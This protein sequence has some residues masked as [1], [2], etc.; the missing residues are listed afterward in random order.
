MSIHNNSAE[1][2]VMS[3]DAWDHGKG[4]SGADL[5]ITT[6]F[7]EIFDNKPRE[8]KCLID[9]G[10]THSFISPLA[11]V[12]KD[13][14]RIKA[15]DKGF[16]YKDFKIMGATSTIFSKCCVV[17]CP[18]EIQKWKCEQK[19]VIADK[20]D[21][22]DMVLGRDFLKGHN[23]WVDHGMDRI[24]ESWIAV[25]NLE[26]ITVE[27]DAVSGTMIFNEPIAV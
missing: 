19:F 25:N 14:A 8:L 23:V 15:N 10:S 24:R 11:I 6:V 27:D 13:L 9:G 20:V 12:D 3:N 2:V 17:E 21:K 16:A 5:L 4:S 22:Y 1:T 26:T 7:A 18:I